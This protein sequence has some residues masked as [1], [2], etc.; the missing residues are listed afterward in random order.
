MTVSGVG[1]GECA[2]VGVRG[3]ESAS[4]CVCCGQ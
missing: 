3:V 1:V 2:G 4:V